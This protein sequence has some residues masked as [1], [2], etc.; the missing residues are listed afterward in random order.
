MT[1]VTYIK[2]PYKEVK[3]QSNWIL[4]S[5]VGIKDSLIISQLLNVVKQNLNTPFEDLYSLLKESY[6][7]KTVRSSC[8]IYQ[9]TNRIEIINRGIFPRFYIELNES[10]N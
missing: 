10:K 5:D 7:N 4:Y 3:S 1:I 8:S 9:T 2:G 6:K